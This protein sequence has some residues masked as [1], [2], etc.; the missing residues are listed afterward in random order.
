M[1]NIVRGVNIPPASEALL[2][3]LPLATANDWSLGPSKMDDVANIYA[4]SRDGSNGDSFLGQ[5]GN[6]AMSAV[7]AN[8]ATNNNVA[9]CLCYVNAPQLDVYHTVSVG[10]LGNPNTQVIADTLTGNTVLPG[11]GTIPLPTG[12]ANTLQANCGQ[13]QSE[14]RC[15]YYNDGSTHW[16]AFGSVCASSNFRLRV[17]LCVDDTVGNPIILSNIDATATWLVS[18]V[19]ILGAYI[20]I[21]GYATDLNAGQTDYRLWKLDLATRSLQETRNG[22]S[23]ATAGISNQAR[24]ALFVHP[25]YGPFM[26]Q[27]RTFYK[28]K[29]SGAVPFFTTT[30]AGGTIT[31]S[32]RTQ[33]HVDKFGGLDSGAME[34]TTNLARTHLYSWGL[35]VASL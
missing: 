7:N 28:L 14:G 4:V 22:P 13:S 26:K 31:D 15:A 9:G 19:Y 17:Q 3:T 20:Y 8:F 30:Y 23:I 5:P 16:T 33:I 18:D 34:T 25:T 27:H 12:N 2:Y 1:F 35:N 32:R 24:E 10:A 29:A 21:L 6:V 11:A